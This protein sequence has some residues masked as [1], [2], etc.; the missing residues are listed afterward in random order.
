MIIA[1]DILEEMTD[2]YLAKVPEI[3]NFKISNPQEG[4]FIK[5]VPLKK[6]DIYKL[7]R[8]N[9]PQ[10]IVTKYILFKIKELKI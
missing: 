2:I 7:L 3:K 8:S 9:K 6:N 10:N 4:E 5:I 1:P